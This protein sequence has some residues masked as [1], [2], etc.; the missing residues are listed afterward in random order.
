[1]GVITIDRRE[2]FNALDVMTARDLRKAARVMARAGTVRCVVLRGTGGVF[3]S[4][5]DLQYIRAGGDDD[6]SGALP[7]TRGVPCSDGAIFKHI[8]ASL[9]GTIMEMRHAPK[10]FSIGPGPTP[11]ERTVPAR[12]PKRIQEERSV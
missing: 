7:P 5:A 8:L 1:V 12:D 4:G 6:S 3:C 10:P 9:H 2:R 11:G